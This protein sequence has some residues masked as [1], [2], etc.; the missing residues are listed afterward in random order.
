M[1]IKIKGAV[2]FNRLVYL[3]ERVKTTEK[4]VS[5]FAEYLSKRV[6]A[7]IDYDAPAY[8]RLVVSALLELVRTKFDE[9]PPQ[10]LPAVQGR[11]HSTF[12]LRDYFLLK[13]VD[14]IS[15]S[16]RF[17]LSVKILTH[18]VEKLVHDH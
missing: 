4:S 7:K 17:A 2:I 5:A 12:R 3:A 14:K 8:Y 11:N 13:L 10:L 16:S 1:P 15:G 6:D 18:R 9:I